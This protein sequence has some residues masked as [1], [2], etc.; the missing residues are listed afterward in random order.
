MQ[1]ELVLTIGGAHSQTRFILAKMEF[2]GE[3]RRLKIG[4]DNIIERVC[5]IGKIPKNRRYS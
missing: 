3:I 4:R 1:K 2:D 5:K